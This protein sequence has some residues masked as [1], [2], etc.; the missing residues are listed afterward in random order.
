MTPR[1]VLVVTA[2]ESVRASVAEVADLR[3]YKL[4]SAATFVEGRKLMIEWQPDVLV[5]SVRLQEH[6]GLHLAIVSRLSSVL[7]K[8]IVIGY[9][10]PVL[11][12]E[13]RHAGALYLTDP[14]TDQITAAIET[15]IQRRE[16]RW[17][18]A[19]TNIAARAAD[20]TV[21]LVDMSYGGFRIELSPDTAFSGDERFDLTV[22]GLRIAALPVWMKQQPADQRMWC[23]A[24]VAEDGESYVAW[25]EFVDSAL[26]HAIQ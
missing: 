6:N 3:G 5:T 25:R 4:L 2:D 13:A 23:G 18:R 14:D 12:A 26:G 16:R 8:T 20:Q 1:T 11:Q 21:R 17:P 22:G 19:R 7:T 10:D 24:A 9:A 15:A